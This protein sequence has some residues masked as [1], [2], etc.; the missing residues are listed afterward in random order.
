MQARFVPCRVASQ[1]FLLTERYSPAQRNEAFSEF[2]L[3]LRLFVTLELVFVLNYH[4]LSL[5]INVSLCSNL[6]VAATRRR[7]ELEMKD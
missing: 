6:P 5:T 2:Q 1:G 7:D 4:W 3:E